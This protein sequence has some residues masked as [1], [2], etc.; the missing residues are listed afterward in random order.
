MSEINWASPHLYDF[1]GMEYSEIMLNEK[2]KEMFEIQLPSLEV[3][4]G[5]IYYKINSVDWKNLPK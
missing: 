1:S 2:L 5:K 4:E 3:R